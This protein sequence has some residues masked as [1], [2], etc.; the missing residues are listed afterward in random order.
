MRSRWTSWLKAS[1][2]SL[3]PTFAIACNARQ[4]F[5]SLWSRRSFLIL[6]TTRWRSSCSSCRKRVTARYPIC[7]SEYFVAEIKLT[8]S[9]WPKS[10]FQP[11]M[12]MYRSWP[13]NREIDSGR[14]RDYL[15]HI[16]LL[17]VAVEIATCKRTLGGFHLAW[18]ILICYL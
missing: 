7:F 12:Y 17:L 9:R 4:L 3:P 1:P 11:S 18:V 15:A 8:A 2:I 13:V 16:F 14:R 5:N 6:L 10:T